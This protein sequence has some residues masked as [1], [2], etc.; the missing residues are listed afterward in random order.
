MELQYDTECNFRSVYNKFGLKVEILPGQW[1]SRLQVQ[2][3]DDQI[4]H[5][6]FWS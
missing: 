1:S 2:K 4:N 3:N 6:I 5:L